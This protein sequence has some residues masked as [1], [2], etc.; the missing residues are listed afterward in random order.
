MSSTLVVVVVNGY[1]YMI[2]SRTF[3]RAMLGAVVLAV[4]LTGMAA[5]ATTWVVDDDGGADRR[6]VWTVEAAA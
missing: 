3:L 2:G 5:G 6:S 4:L 1:D